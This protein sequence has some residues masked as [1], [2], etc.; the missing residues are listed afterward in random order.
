MAA[1]VFIASSMEAKS[2]AE[3]LA[4][5]LSE[6]ELTP[7]RWWT[8]FKPGDATLDRLRLLTDYV[9]G[10]VVIWDADDKIWLRNH[11]IATARDN[12]YL[13]Y[14]LFLSKLGPYRTGVLAHTT[15]NMPSDV[16]GT[17]V[18]R[19]GSDFE[20]AARTLVDQLVPVTK[21]K[22][23]Q[24]VP[25]AVDESVY[26]S[27]LDYKKIPPNYSGRSLYLGDGGA[28][29][30][31]VST[32]PAYHS[33]CMSDRLDVQALHAAAIDSLKA[34]IKTI[35]RVVSLGPADG[36]AE[37]N[38]LLQMQGLGATPEWIPVDISQGLLTFTIYRRQELAIPL[39][40]V[41]DFEEPRGL[42]Y[43]ADQIWPVREDQPATPRLPTLITMLGGTFGDLDDDALQWITHFK[44]RLMA[45]DYVLL[46]I[47]AKGSAWAGDKDP[48]MSIADYPESFR[49]FVSGGLATRLG[50]PS[51]G[52]LLE[53]FD[54]RI[55]TQCVAHN[56]VP[57]SDT[58]EVI[59]SVSKY[60][61]LRSAR[62]DWDQC[63]D[64]FSKLD[65]LKLMFHK[66]G[67]AI[68]KGEDVW[69]AG[70]VLLKRV[71]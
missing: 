6:K 27:H 4:R 59:D 43:I 63:V 29:F 15:I 70:V 7:L 51:A 60:V 49:R 71:D 42:T 23:P 11:E 19:Y 62:F 24:I 34:E 9:D 52:E 18:I 16:A 67:P 66:L 54:K 56:S 2:K 33:W 65:N 69:R 35:D 8:V 58:I 37:H 39:G 41:G 1:L 68:C 36:R 47:P 21:P 48:R 17:T 22:S 25:V 20:T 44:A 57:K 53:L 38:L 30:L 31:A 26:E 32:D 64:W 40:V 5:V 61:A 45:G 13:E 28:R 50:S 3:I 14:G 55:A 12:C 10:A 46:D